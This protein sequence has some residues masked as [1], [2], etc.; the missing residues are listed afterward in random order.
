MIS[1]RHIPFAGPNENPA[2]LARWNSEFPLFVFEWIRRWD[3]C[4]RVSVMIGP[5]APKNISGFRS[6]RDAPVCLRHDAHESRKPLWIAQLFGDLVQTSFFQRDRHGSFLLLA[7]GQRA[8]RRSEIAAQQKKNR[9]FFFNRA[10]RLPMTCSF[11]A[12]GEGMKI[13]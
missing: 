4:N 9:P 12:S 8:F 5:R 7:F 3:K 6:G 11:R 13:D 2:L 1:G 10:L